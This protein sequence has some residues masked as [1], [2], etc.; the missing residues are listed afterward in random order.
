MTDLEWDDS[1]E[2]V[3]MIR[4]VGDYERAARV[5][6]RLSRAEPR[7]SLPTRVTRFG[8]PDGGGTR[9]ACRPGETG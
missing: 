1:A 4:F 8:Q 3:A 2:L 6:R 9:P 7:P 5:W